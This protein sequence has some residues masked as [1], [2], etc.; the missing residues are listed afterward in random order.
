MREQNRPLTGGGDFALGMLLMVS[1]TAIGN[2]A[3]AS[4]FLL[5]PIPLAFS[6][7]PRS[8]RASSAHAFARP[9]NASVVLNG[10]RS[11]INK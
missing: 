1:S 8:Q 2:V 3:P 9:R 6:V 10:Q 5:E 11:A 4:Q 7:Q